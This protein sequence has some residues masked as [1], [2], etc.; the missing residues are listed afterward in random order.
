MRPLR[1][2]LVLI[3]HSPEEWRPELVSVLA[4]VIVMPE[5][6]T[7]KELENL[8]D[9]NL[10]FFIFGES[11]LPGPRILLKNRNAEENTHSSTN[12]FTVGR[13]VAE[14]LNLAA[15]TGEPVSE[16]IPST[17]NLSPQASCRI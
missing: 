14:A 10:P 13:L 5:E 8:K 3:G 6:V 17:L 1:A 16:P 15:L 11:E 12:F 7:T 2:S 9:R 4:G